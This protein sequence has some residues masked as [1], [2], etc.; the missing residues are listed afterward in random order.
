[1][2]P[3]I[4]L[5]LT[6]ACG[7]YCITNNLK[8]PSRP[9]IVE[10]I[11]ENQMLLLGEFQRFCSSSRLLEVLILCRP[12]EWGAKASAAG[13]GFCFLNEYVFKEKLHFLVT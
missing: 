8:I 5:G 1:M 13:E 2:F 7:G 9:N 3:R 11:I 6:E 4:T 10:G 12:Y